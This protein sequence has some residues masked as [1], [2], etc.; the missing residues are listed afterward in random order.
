MS[1][2]KEMKEEGEFQVHVLFIEN[3]HL[4]P[5]PD[6][7]ENCKRYKEEL[8]LD[9]DLEEAEREYRVLLQKAKRPEY[10]KTRP[11][12]ERNLF[13]IERRSQAPTLYDV[14]NIV[15]KRCAYTKWKKAMSEFIGLTPIQTEPKKKVFTADKDHVFIPVEVKAKEF[16][17]PEKPEVVKSDKEETFDEREEN[18]KS[19]PNSENLETEDQSLTPKKYEVLFADVD[20]VFIPDELTA[21]DD[22]ELEEPT[23]EDSED[24]DELSETLPPGGN[25][26]TEDQTLKTEENQEE[27]KEEEIFHDAMD[28]ET[29]E[30]KPPVVNILFLEVFIIF[31]VFIRKMIINLSLKGTR[32]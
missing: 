27:E 5:I 10:S 29:K 20:Q 22:E 23:P 11:H 1:G 13:D 21:K 7:L 30:H 32:I 12:Y 4:K 2:T 26:D 25:P 31:Q 19:V 18:K 24:R 14:L 15:S 6:F 28:G 16:E 9:N 8:K 17:S 3:P